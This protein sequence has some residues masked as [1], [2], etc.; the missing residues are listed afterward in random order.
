MSELEDGAYNIG[1]QDGYLAAKKDHEL[2][3]VKFSDMERGQRVLEWIPALEQVFD[4]LSNKDESDHIM[5]D[6]AAR[7]GVLLG[8]LKS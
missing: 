8:E 5:Q 1:W 3:L 4:S 6:S 7:L 2:H